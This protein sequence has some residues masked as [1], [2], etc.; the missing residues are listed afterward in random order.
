[1]SSMTL[2]L[3]TGFTSL[4]YNQVSSSWSWFEDLVL[5]Y[6]TCLWQKKNPTRQTRSLDENLLYRGSSLI[7]FLT[8]FHCDVSIMSGVSVSS[9]WNISRFFF[10]STLMCSSC[11]F[12]LSERSRTSQSAQRWSFR[13]NFLLSCHE[14]SALRTYI[15][16]K[17]CYHPVLPKP[18]R[19]S[20]KSI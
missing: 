13:S 4:G 8:S 16:Y 2:L 1:M 6:V 19:I 11:S 12:C 10:V 20:G 18:T 17:H 7:S 9:R 14:P 3:R 5:V 15:K